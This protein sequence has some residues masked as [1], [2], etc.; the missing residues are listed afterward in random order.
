MP[1]FSL[2]YSSCIPESLSIFVVREAIFAVGNLLF[3]TVDTYSKENSYSV[4]HETQT[5]LFHY[6]NAANASY[7]FNCFN[8]SALINGQL[9]IL[10]IYPIFWHVLIGDWQQL[11]QTH[12][13]LNIVVLYRQFYTSF[14]Y[15]LKFFNW[16]LTNK[17]PESSWCMTQSISAIKHE[18]VLCDFNQTPWLRK[19][20]VILFG[21]WIP[22]YCVRF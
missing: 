16:Y 6:F 7:Q 14:L 22:C 13:H 19:S 3:I 2:H 17:Q 21:V 8:T 10:W 9:S 11:H 20:I 1:L 18:S 15:K 12:S 5:P 4:I